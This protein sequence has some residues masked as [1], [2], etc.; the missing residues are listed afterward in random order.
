MLKSILNLEGAQGLTK[1]EQNI[2][3][4]GGYTCPAPRSESHC[5]DIGGYWNSNNGGCYLYPAN[6]C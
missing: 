4:G 6:W 2:T 1:N 5:N 3:F